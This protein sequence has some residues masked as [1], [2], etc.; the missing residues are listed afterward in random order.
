MNIMKRNILFALA[1][2]MT[3]TSYAQDVIS[4]YL[5]NGKQLR[6]PNGIETADMHFWGTNEA[7]EEI[8]SLSAASGNAQ[9][10]IDELQVTDFTN[11]GNQY[12]IALAWLR[13]WDI[14]T[15]AHM[16][17]CI[18]REP[19]VSIENC[20]SVFFEN[21]Y[22]DE[23]FTIFLLQKIQQTSESPHLGQPRYVLLGDS[24]CFFRGTDNAG[25][26]SWDGHDMHASGYAGRFNWCNYPLECGETYYYR[27]IARVPY[28]YEQNESELS[29]VEPSGE[30]R[31]IPQKSRRIFARFTVVSV[32]TTPR[33]KIFN[34]DL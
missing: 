29:S 32:I 14:P 16:G 9:W 28:Y 1:L 12:A 21:S 8:P 26:R 17:I 22:D 31:Y 13:E 23:N 25:K 30:C 7:G 19:D 18:G 34:S 5:K 27:V 24:L 2:F 11:K 6:F 3:M 20:D 33:R 10:G 4:V 15:T